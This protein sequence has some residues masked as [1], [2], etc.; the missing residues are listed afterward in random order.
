[1]TRLR[2]L[3]A[4]LLCV[5]SSRADDRTVAQP[6]RLDWTFT[7]SNR[8]V[9]DP[10]ADLLGP[11]YDSRKQTYEL[12]LPPRKDPKQ[13]LGVIVFISAG[14]D[15]GGW[16]PFE[17][18]CMELGLA[19]LAVRN[20]GNSVPPPRR[21]RIVLDCLD[22]LRRQMP[23]DPD[24]TYI[25][26]FSGGARIACGIAFALPEMFGGMLP[27][28]AAGDLRAEPWLRHRAI[29]RLSAALITGPSDFNRGEVERWKAP[30]WSGI[31]MRTKTWVQPNL[32][33]A[34]PSAATLTEAV[35]WLEAG[36]PARAEA[37]KKFPTSRGSASITPTRDE[38]AKAVFEEGKKLLA[39]RATLHR[40]LMQLKGTLERWPDTASGKAARTLLEEYEAQP[41]KPW[42]ADD[43]TELRKQLLA[44]A[45]SLGDYAL[46]GIPAGSPYEKS[47][48]ALAAQA[49]EYWS[50]LISDAPDAD[51]AKEGRKLVPA[52]KAAAEK[53]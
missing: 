40:G 33:H 9:A 6:T 4:L 23:I 24:R 31:G 37:A 46:N 10:P 21:C 15:A 29:D 11:G 49:L 38:S 44:E 35:K 48:P 25:S 27:L 1:M 47:R 32:G 34:M 50:A 22:D 52:L 20:A 26:G 42:E 45:R 18:A 5:S 12:R 41:Q 8:S 16:K 3:L 43:A 36:R 28:C 17:P 14:N 51:Y 39:D 30:F 2:P 13:P 19:F 7:A 53:K